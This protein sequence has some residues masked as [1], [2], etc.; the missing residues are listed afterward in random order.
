MR[1]DDAAQLRMGRLALSL[2]SATACV[3]FVAGAIAFYFGPIFASWLNS[4]AAVPLLLANEILKTG[5]PVPSSWYFG[6]DEIWTLAPQVFAMPFVAT[7]GIS[8]LALK[9][10]NLLCLGVAVSFVTLS[11]HRVTRS[12]PFAILVAAGVLAPFSALQE[13]AVYSQTAYGWF[14]AQFALLIYL[15]IRMQ[16]ERGGE[17]WRLFGRV[18]WTAALYVLFLANLAIDSPMR[19]GAY[20]VLP[21]LAVTLA[22]PISRM[23]SRA[24]IAWTVVAFLVGAWLHY[25]ISKHVLSDAG[26]TRRLLNIDEWRTN[27]ARIWVGLP[28]LTGWMQAPYA[29]VFGVLDRARFCVMALAAFVVLLAPAGNGEG[30]AECRFFA[31]V[32]GVMLLVVFVVLTVG[33]LNVDPSCDRYLLAPALLSLA[34]FM[35][36]LWCRFRSN[37]RSIAAIAGIFVLMFCGAAVMRVS[38]LGSIAFDRPC[39]APANACRLESVLAKTGLRRGFATYWK[40]NLTTV[41]SEGRIETCGVSLKPQL[42]PFRWLVSKDCFDPPADRYF[43]ALTQPEIAAVGR[44]LLISEAGAPEQIVTADE[45]EIWIYSAASAKLDWLR[46]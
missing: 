8:A 41:I 19:A 14:T 33:R 34:A 17:P 1:S 10:G 4:D 21:V 22:F 37:S 31:R 39:D 2:I 29:S 9:L 25:V 12:W 3:L 11:L 45:Y 26:V 13:A 23:R 30:S 7:L 38:R 28:M 20:W 42:A 44:P 43:L 24:L 16:D 46:R 40:G 27:L 35:A 32:A 36:I 5:L 18:P 15:A 6:N